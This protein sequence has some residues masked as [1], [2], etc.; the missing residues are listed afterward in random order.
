[1]TANDDS[2]SLPQSGQDT[3][4]FYQ[5]YWEERKGRGQIHTRE[6]MWIPPRIEYAVEFLKQYF[7]GSP[8]RVLDCGCGEGTTGMLLRR[9]FGN[10]VKLIGTDIST[11]AAELAAPFYDQVHAVNL[12]KDSLGAVLGGEAVNAIICLEVLEHLFYPEQAVSKFRQ[13]LKPGGIL[14]ASFPNIALWKYRL[15]LLGGEFPIGYTTV[16]PSEHIQNFTLESFRI[17]LEQEGFRVQG[18]SSQ[19]IF[20]GLFKPIR[21]WRKAL[22]NAHA[23][24]GAQIVVCAKPQ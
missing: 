23:L 11:V 15:D 14:I 21:F 2:E 8:Q 9:T 16:H 17:L 24:F 3:Q 10:E 19:Q 7:S 22:R 5:R 1:V 6:G 18:V 13:S 12:E 20:P 4:E